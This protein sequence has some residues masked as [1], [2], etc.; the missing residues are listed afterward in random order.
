[1][2]G[3]ARPPWG[4]QGPRGAEPTYPVRAL[5]GAAGG[6]DYAPPTSCPSSAGHIATHQRPSSSWCPENKAA[7]LERTDL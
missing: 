1:M 7:S 4:V 3:G 5:R 6:R 2:K